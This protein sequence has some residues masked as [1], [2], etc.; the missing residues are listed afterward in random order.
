MHRNKALG[1]EKVQFTQSTDRGIVG[2]ID[3]LCARA[4]RD[5]AM[6]SINE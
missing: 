3:G 4:L 1:D 2:H 6:S 5:L